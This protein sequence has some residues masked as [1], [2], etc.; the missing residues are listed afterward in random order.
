MDS[1][2]WWRGS[3]DAQL[4]PLQEV[5]DQLRKTR[6]ELD[7]AFPEWRAAYDADPAGYARHD[8]RREFFVTLQLTLTNAQLSYTFMKDQLCDTQWWVDRVGEHRPVMVEQALRE[9]ALMVKFF[10]VYATATATE[11]TLRAIVRAGPPFTCPE[12][13]AFASV[14]AHVPR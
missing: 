14:V 5:K 7:A 1:V 3:A 6:L 11:E 2:E 10:T 4:T 13:A 8:A 12:T 9:Y